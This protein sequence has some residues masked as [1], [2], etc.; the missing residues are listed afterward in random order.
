MTSKIPVAD[1]NNLTKIEVSHAYKDWINNNVPGKTFDDRVGK[2]VK[3]YHRCDGKAPI[4]LAAENSW[5]V[6]EDIGR[7]VL[8]IMGQKVPERKE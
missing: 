7:G 2:L 8:K 6:C 4:Q 5:E 3:L 1:K